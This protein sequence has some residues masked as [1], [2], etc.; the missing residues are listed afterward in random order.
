MPFSLRPSNRPTSRPKKRLLFFHE[1]PSV[2]QFNPFIRSG[3]RS[4]ETYPS[5]L[6]SIFEWHN[7]TINIWSH[8]IP[9]FLLYM[10]W[11]FDERNR[12]SCFSAVLCLMASVGYHTCMTCHRHYRFWIQFDVCGVY[13][14]LIGS[15]IETFTFSLECQQGFLMAARTLTFAL[16]VFGMYLSLKAKSPLTRGIPMI[17][18]LLLRIGVLAYRSLQTEQCTSAWKLYVI[19]EVLSLMGGVINASRIPERWFKSVICSDHLQRVGPFDYWL[20]SHQIMHVFVVIAIFCM[21]K[22]LA[23][24]AKFANMYPK[25]F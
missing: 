11:I 18:L 15:Q 19:A 24:D 12:W 4:G 16:G 1:V 9:A 21:R 10:A 25:C 14:F 20:N 13:M 2:L 5:A 8:L 3:Y 17:G 7:E 23:L 6:Q 22:G